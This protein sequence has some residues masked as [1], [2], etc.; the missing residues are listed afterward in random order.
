MIAYGAGMVNKETIISDYIANVNFNDPRFDVAKMKRELSVL[1]QEEPGIKLNWITEKTVNEV[2]GKEVAVD[3]V[4]SVKVYYT[5]QDAEG[6]LA[7][8]SVLIYGV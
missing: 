8:K 5:L 6:K 1:L 7:P 2:S 3:K 4:A